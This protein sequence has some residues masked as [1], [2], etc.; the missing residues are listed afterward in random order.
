VSGQLNTDEKSAD[1]T[2]AVLH[3]GSP[4]GMYG[5][6]RWI[7]A[8]VRHLSRNAIRSV[9]GVI[10]D[11]PN[12]EDEA[13]LCRHAA[14]LGFE[15]VTFQSFGKLSFSAVRQIRDYICDN[16][17]SLLHTHG[18]KTDLIGVIAVRGTNCRIV[19]TPHGWSAVRAGLK[20]QIY[21][22]LNRLAFFFMDA[23]V[24][25]SPDLFNGLERWPGLG[26]KL[27][28]IQNGVDLREIDG[29]LQAVESDPERDTSDQFKVGYVGQLIPR[30]GLDV[31]LQAFARLKHAR[32]RL[33][34]VG[35]GPQKAE[36][37]SLAESLGEK[38]TTEFLGFRS[39]RIRLLQGW[40]AFVLPSSLEGIPRCLLEAMA[41][42]VPIIASDIPGCR[43]LIKPGETGLLFAPGD[44][45]TLTGHLEVLANDSELRSNLATRGNDFV[46]EHFSAGRMASEYQKLYFDLVERQ[47]SVS[48]HATSN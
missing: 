32:K 14:E 34:I 45:E 6:E 29:I 33:F 9:I 3:L 39:D 17:I 41:S 11:D 35:D 19:S 46:R 21:E 40:Q 22:F 10:R 27:V 43:E 18:Y 37:E 38:Q 47:I 13:P 4:T 5:A 16:N 28:L 24:P 44:V 31:L 8:L 25:L 30:K 1:E 15:S 48:D 42:G 7:L 2:L 26:S 20:L 12:Q 23:V 36:L